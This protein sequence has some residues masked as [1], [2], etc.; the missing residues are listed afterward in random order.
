MQSKTRAWGRCKDCCCSF[1]NDKGQLCSSSKAD[2]KRGMKH[3]AGETLRVD[4]SWMCA[5]REERP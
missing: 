2:G 4:Y 3:Q 1:P 5:V